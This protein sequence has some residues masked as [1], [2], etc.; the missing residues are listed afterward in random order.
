MALQWLPLAAQD[1]SAFSPLPP[2]F[3]HMLDA[4]VVSA[5]ALGVNWRDIEI[6]DYNVERDKYQTLEADIRRLWPAVQLMTIALEPVQDVVYTGISAIP[7]DS[8]L[9][10]KRELRSMKKAARLDRKKGESKT[11]T[12]SLGSASLEVEA[13]DEQEPVSTDTLRVEDHPCTIAQA[14]LQGYRP[15]GN[16]DGQ[17]MA[18]LVMDSTVE[19]PFDS[20][21]DSMLIIHL[22]DRQNQGL[23]SFVSDYAAAVK[24]PYWGVMKLAT[25]FSGYRIDR[26]YQGR[27]RDGRIE[28]IIRRHQLGILEHPCRCDE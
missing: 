26:A 12:V 23:K 8:I 18:V 14:E 7:S 5:P 24:V 20:F 1:T 17:G 16:L 10:Q 21:G 15:T 11:Y 28:H 2:S 13:E 6:A 3:V 9:A 4:A 27:G 19:V 22:L 25:R